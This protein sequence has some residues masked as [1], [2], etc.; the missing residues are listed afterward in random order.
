MHERVDGG[1]MKRLILSLIVVVFLFSTPGFAQQAG[2]NINVLPLFPDTT[3]PDYYLKGDGYLQRQVEPTIAASTRNPDH[4]LAF[5][6]DYRAVDIPDDVGLG[7]GE[8]I[9][10]LMDT[11]NLMMATVNWMNFPKISLPPI[12]AAEA[13]VG[14]SRSYDGGLTWSGGYLPGNLDD[15]SQA[16][17]DAPI[18]GLEAA[19]DPV[20]VPGPCGTFYLVFVAFTRGDQSKIVVAR[21]ED[22][23]NDED[24]DPIVYQGMTVIET[25]NNA[26]HGYFLDKP[27]INLDIWRGSGGPEQCGH[28]LYVTY[29]TFNGF[30][31][32]DKI[33]SK[34]NFAMSEDGGLSFSTQKINKNFGQNQGSVIAVDPRAGTP[35]GTGGGTIYVLWRHFFD[36]DTII[37]TKTLDYGNKWSNPKS[38][39]GPGSIAAFDQPT[40]P[41]NAF[42][43]PATLTARSNGFPA[44]TVT[45]DGTLFAA[46]QERVNT[47]AEVD[48]PAFGRP[49]TLGSPRIVL[50]STANGGTGWSDRKAVD[51]G[52]RNEPF[53]PAITPDIG[54]PVPPTRASGPQIQPDLSFGGGRLMLAYLESRGV[55]GID[56]GTGEETV[57][58]LD[59]SPTGYISDYR[60]VM[61]VRAAVLNPATGVTESTTQVSRYPIHVGADLEDGQQLADVAAI[62]FPC[63]EEIDPETDDPSAY[64]PCT[65]QINRFNIPQSGGGK[66]PFMGDYIDLVPTLQFVSDAEGN[67]RW[68]TEPGDT[69]YQGFH[70]IW[71]D[72]RHLS[73]PTYPAATQEFLRYQ[74]YGPPGIGGSCFNPGSRNTD[75][76]TAKVDASVIIS[77]PTTYKNLNTRRGFPLSIRNPT[78]SSRFYRLTITDGNERATFAVDP[79][80]AGGDIDTGD[81]E[82]FAYSGIS[83][84]VYVD[85]GAQ[86]PIRI[87]VEEITASPG[88]GIPGSVIPGGQFGVVTLNPDPNN[89]VMNEDPDENVEPVVGDAFVINP[90]PDNA[91]VINNDPENAFVINPFV[92]NAFV[93]NTTAENAFVINAFVINAFVINA[94]VINS[95]VY[96]VIDVTWPITPGSG[97]T[98]TS[99]LPVINIDNAEQFVG[100][101][102]FQLLVSKNSSYGSYLGDDDICSALAAEAIQQQQVVSNVT[103]NPNEVATAF[104]INPAPENAFVINPFPENAFV[105]NSTFTMA[106]SET[107]SAKALGDTN[108]GT[109]K[110]PPASNTHT[111]TLR[112]FQLKP[113]SE[114]GDFVYN[115]DPAMG[116]DLPAL[117]V[118][119]TNCTTP[120]CIVSNA[121]DLI[122]EDVDTTPIVVQAGSEF[123][124]PAWTLKNQ[125]VNDALAE[126]RDLRHGFF[127]SQD[128]NVVLEILGDEPTGTD[129]RI[130]FAQP[131]PVV[132]IVAGGGGTQ[133]IPAT[134]VEVPIDVTPG[135]YW[136]VLFV[137]DYREVSERNEPNNQIAIRITVEVPN[138]PP[139]VEDSLEDTPEETLLEAHMSATDPDAGDVLTYTI[140]TQ[141]TDGEL[142]LVDANTGAFSYNPDTDFNGED[143]FTFEVSDGELTS[144]SVGT[145]T[146]NVTPVNDPPVVAP[147]SVQVDE[148][149]TAT[150]TLEI[151][152]P[153]NDPSDF[154]YSVTTQ[155]SNGEASFS[156]TEIGTF[157]YDP[158][159]D[160]N[161]T[162]TFTVTVSDGSDPSAAQTVTITISAINDA[163]VAADGST[164]TDEDT[165]G[166]TTL[167]ASDVDGDS[168]TYT[169]ETQPGNGT[170]SGTA[171]D[172]T[173]TPDANFVGTDSFTFSASDSVLSSNIATFTITVNP[174]ND[175]PV[176][177][178]DTATVNQNSGP[179]AIDVLLNDSDVD[180]DPIF[181]SAVGPAANGTTAINGNVTYEPEQGFVGVDSFEYTLSDGQGGV[182]TANVTVTVIDPV[183]DWGFVG[184]L[185]PWRPNY[186]VKAGSGVPLKW[187][188]TDPDTNQQINSSGADPEVRIA[189]PFECSV[190]QDDSSVEVVEDTGSSDLRYTGN[191]WQLNWDT[192]GLAKGCYN[193][194]VFSNHTDQLDGPFRIRL[195]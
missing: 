169:V 127:L 142:T 108:D 149:G 15:M 159:D 178:D 34:M 140:L 97:D 9:A 158:D 136:L 7:E 171:P 76:L 113:T 143:S 121:P 131:D 125:G 61:D 89:P 44:A 56:L 8:Q 117:S 124:F 28:R 45:S 42:N 107:T 82:I 68:A 63:S 193:I 138:D 150:G 75:V 16:S 116:G 148:D 27:H 90:V 12:A 122:A 103:Q 176:A 153:D 39:I 152:D 104:V 72:N 175:A 119:P 168:L 147:A 18:R 48:D 58:E 120:E 128:E 47:T 106:P 110:G 161:G 151:T 129:R 183:P 77:A 80:M 179:N 188:Y 102:A 46:W 37:M 146:I 49:D 20:L 73:P 192:G 130:G 87:T 65:R 112:A 84:V 156:E 51:F 31:T 23:N 99:Y 98:A 2:N 57:Q 40:I 144:E 64:P 36:P 111:V 83:Q 105:I 70:T 115:P 182:V 186:S 78:E 13:W 22:L 170:L 24:G 164:A 137:D 5:F 155:P 6:N 66:S 14:M 184:L 4:L 174:V 26:E 132:N 191:E 67:W 86:E 181:V 157:I 10:L 50:T 1:R 74:E 141:T 25:G 21:Y 54:A 139:V 81:V 190:G 17:L 71:A 133:I 62:N 96:D 92:D 126:I 55:A 35:K 30:S 88:P 154:T 166:T 32:A 109:L 100:N 167:S 173:Y 85:A 3:D 33:Q 187:Y 162:D 177:L 123:T 189:G 101:Y 38:I 95:N 118:I 59:L 53:D 93:I 160:F 41:S 135:E 29:S 91:F 172:L 194:R 163:P 19:T 60:R 11:A 195:R 114:L 180:N 185:T 52:D 145:V 79:V 134:S 69:P 43:D 94:F 165:G